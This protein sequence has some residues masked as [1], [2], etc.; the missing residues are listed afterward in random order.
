MN[1]QDFCIDLT[2]LSSCGV[3]YVTPEDIDTLAASAN[4][5]D[6]NVHR[7]DLGGCRDR[8]TFTRR[9]ASGLSLPDRYGEDWPALVSY[10]KGMD[11]LPSRGHVVLF[12]HPDEWRQSDP[13]GLDAALDTLE[14]TAAIWAAEG[15]AFF[16]FLPQTA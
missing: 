11:G 15:I 5:D 13:A 7:V 2:D 10:L 14:E 6:F 16:V 9:L 8:A 1:V 4:Q 12:T 3:Y